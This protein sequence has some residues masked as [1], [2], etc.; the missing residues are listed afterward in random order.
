MEEKARAKP[1]TWLGLVLVFVFQLLLLYPLHRYLDLPRWVEAN[2]MGLGEALLSGVRSTL[3][4]LAYSP[5]Y[6]LLYAGLRQ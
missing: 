4:P 3:A 1:G 6:V 5:P 2:Y